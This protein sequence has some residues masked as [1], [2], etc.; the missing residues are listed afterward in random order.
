M[1]TQ[2]IERYTDVKCVLDAIKNGDI[3]FA[4]WL[5]ENKEFS[6]WSVFSRRKEFYRLREKMTP[7][8][9]MWLY[10]QIESARDSL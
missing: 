6:R 2:T 5:V 10:S 9:E 8:I 3:H 4:E 7:I 1:R